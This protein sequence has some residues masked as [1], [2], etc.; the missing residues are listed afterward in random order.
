MA[1][2]FAGIASRPRTVLATTVGLLLFAAATAAGAA[3]DL[4]LN[5]PTTASSFVSAAYASAAAVDGAASTR[6][7]STHNDNEWFQV[8]LGTSTTINTVTLNWEAAYGKA[9]KIAVSTD[10]ATWR[11]VYSTTTGAGGTETIRFAA[12]SARYVRM[13]GVTRATTYGYSLWELGVS[14][15]TTG[16]ANAL[17]T[18]AIFAPGS[19]WYT[20]IP[21]SVPLHP[22][23]A[24]FAAEIQRQIKAYYGTVNLNTTSY[25]SPVYTAAAGAATR[26]VQLTDCQHKGYLDSNLQSQW[27]AVPIPASAAPSAGTDGEMTVYQPSTDTIWEFWQTKN[28]YGN[29]SACWG[30]RMTGASKNPGIWTNPYGTTATGLPFLGGQVTAEELQRGEIRHAI[31]IA[32]VDLEKS[33]IFSWPATRSDGYN[34]T[35]AANRIPEGLRL[36]LDPNLNVDA[37][38]LHPVA[39]IIAKAAQKYGLVVWDHAG[40]LS[41][42]LQNP[43]SYTQLGRPDPY[44]ALFGATPAYAVMNGFPWSRMQFL[45]M[46]Y[47]K[48]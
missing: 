44:P 21:A 43:K 12:T 32:L 24:N 25:A 2:S 40:A 6:W 1:S 15:E 29:W 37:L 3:T 48:P 45:P 46:N 39:R 31:G 17:P 30:G 27:A 35:G 5:K 34:P 36:R 19:F 23:S 41:L 9:Y 33:G 16:T 14:N 47:G 7:A 20:P 11:T 18:D 13:I 10:N 8:D 42:R 28:S 26:K 4:A 38:A 22:N